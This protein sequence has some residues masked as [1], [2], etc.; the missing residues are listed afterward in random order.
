MPIVCGWLAF[1]GTL[2]YGFAQ[3]DWVRLETARRPLAAVLSD[4]V[5]PGIQGRRPLEQLYFAVAFR[6]F[7]PDPR[8]FHFLA[9]LIHCANTVLIHLLLRRVTTAAVALLGATFFAVHIAGFTVVYWAACAPEL[10]TT[11]FS[12]AAIHAA[13]ALPRRDGSPLPGTRLRRWWRPWAWAAA[14]YLA[15]LGAKETP[16]LLPLVILAIA[17]AAG[18]SI[19]A[20]A[21]RALPLILVGAAYAVFYATVKEG[22]AKPAYP[23]DLSIGGLSS[24]LGLYLVWI[25]GL[26]RPIRFVNEAEGPDRAFAAGMVAFFVLSGLVISLRMGPQARRLVLAGLVWLGA[27]LAPTIAVKGHTYQYLIYLA[28]PG[29]VLVAAPALETILKLAARWRPKVVPLVAGAGTA[30]IAA[31]GIWAAVTTEQIAIPKRGTWNRE[32]FVLRR[33]IIADRVLDQVAADMRTLAPGTVVLFV[34]GDGKRNWFDSN[35]SSALG[36]GVALPVHFGRPNLEVGFV[37]RGAI[38]D[39]LAGRQGIFYEYLRDGSLKS[40]GTGRIQ[41]GMRIEPGTGGK[42]PWQ[43]EGSHPGR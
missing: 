14:L 33:A 30:A 13:L 7:G 32:H 12:L 23:A 10:L 26:G 35:F 21:R 20:S 8:A 16:L 2:R 24:R 15:A 37:E 27:V 11:F 43:V 39:D 40:L 3:D 42:M 18:F 25:L 4:W 6:P 36:E 34:S 17:P 22:I 29:L 31:V 19:A 5:T 38:L 1:H 41:R 28:L 9:I